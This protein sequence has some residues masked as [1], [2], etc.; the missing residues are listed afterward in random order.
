MKVLIVNV[1]RLI[2]YAH[3]FFLQQVC[4][5]ENVIDGGVIGQ[6]VNLGS[7]NCYKVIGFTEVILQDNELL[8]NLSFFGSC[9]QCF[10]QSGKIPC[11]EPSYY[12]LKECCGNR[13]ITLEIIYVPEGF[14]MSPGQGIYNDSFTFG[15]CFYWIQD[16]ILGSEF[17]V[18]SYSTLGFTYK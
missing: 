8:E 17:P 18:V 15:P 5:P 16:G 9:K 14:E 12:T 11:G 13:I 1:L 2:H 7:P 4:C 10:Q 3:I 6:Y